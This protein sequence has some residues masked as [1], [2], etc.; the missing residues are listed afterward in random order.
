M[1]DIEIVQKKGMA[2]IDSKLL[3]KKL[4]VASYHAD[5]IRRRIE[6]YG[7]V[8]GE[9]Y[10]ISKM[11]KSKKMGRPTVDYLLT[12]DMAKELCMLENNEK[13][14]ATR[15]HFIQAEKE[16]RVYEKT[17]IEGMATRKTLTQA[18]DESG[19]NERMHGRGYSN[20]TRLVY[21]ITGLSEKYKASSSKDFRSTLT[22]EELKRVEVAESLIKPML[23]LEKQYSDIKETLR[24]LF[25]TKGLSLEKREK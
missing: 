23:E 11:S 6:N 4:E 16:L 24:P 18:I 14:K 17:R 15:K 25:V 21:S 10:F 2:L 19:E 22:A 12:L 3:H 8:E 7:F 5:W 9:D 1:F 13:G 20:Y